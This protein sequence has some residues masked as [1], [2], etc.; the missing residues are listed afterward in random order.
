MTA[1]AAKKPRDS[2]VA[3]PLGRVQGTAAFHHAAFVA[4]LPLSNG[5]RYTVTSQCVS[6]VVSSNASVV[7]MVG[8]RLKPLATGA[9]N[10]SVTFGS[11]GFDS[12][13]VRVEDAVL[14]PVTSLVLTSSL[15]SGNS[16]QAQVGFLSILEHFGH[17]E[18][19]SNYKTPK[20]PI[21]LLLIESHYSVL[22]SSPSAPWQEV[23]QQQ[24]QE[25]TAAFSEMDVFYY[26]QLSFPVQ[27]CSPLRL[28]LLKGEATPAEKE[29]RMNVPP[30]EDVLRTRW[31]GCR[32]EWNGAEQIL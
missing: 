20:S 21:W 24:E 17:H 13:T 27:S 19:G 11:S 30:L 31:A 14:D 1:V 6:T 8:T 12:V 25:Q 16:L 29:T 3:F 32:V 22:W 18:V 15:N 7:E 28:T 9:A 2:C 26:D 4:E 10:V 5:Q 23:V